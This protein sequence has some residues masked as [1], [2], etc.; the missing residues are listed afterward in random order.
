M[1]VQ[2]LL[3]GEPL[4]TPAGAIAPIEAVLFDKDGTLSHSEPMLQALASARIERGLTLFEQ[5][6]PQTAASQHGLPPRTRQR[7][8]ALLEQTY[9]LSDSGLDPG[10]ITAVAA[11]DHNLI[12]TATVFTQV[13]LSWPDAL[14]L[15]ELSF[16]DTDA[17][18][19][20]GAPNPPR[21]T[22]IGRAHV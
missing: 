21:P 18:H 9:G 10:G 14:H 20:A 17:L 3:Q 1:I 12:A 22:E 2:L 8:Q 11:R 7:L 15:A 5:H 16:A 13:G 19:G 4:L 6:H